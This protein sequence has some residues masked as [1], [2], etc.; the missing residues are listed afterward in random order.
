MASDDLNLTDAELDGLLAPMRAFA[1]QQPAPSPQRAQASPSQLVRLYGDHRFLLVTVVAIE[2]RAPQLQ[3]VWFAVPE[4]EVLEDWAVP[5]LAFRL[6]I[7]IEAEEYA[8]LHEAPKTSSRAYTVADICSDRHAFATD[9]V[10]HGDG[11]A[12]MRWLADLSVGD[13]VYMWPPRQH[14]VPQAGVRTAFV[15]DSSALPA[16]LSI[17]RTRAHGEGSVLLTS[18]DPAELAHDYPFLDGVTVIHTAHTPGALSTAFIE[19]PWERLQAVW[20]AGESG[21]MKTIR[22]F[23]RNTLGLNK[24]RAQVHGYWRAGKT[25]TRIDIEKMRLMRDATA[26]GTDPDTLEDQLEDL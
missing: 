15:V 16:A 23:C 2:E 22:T 3:R 6:E 8:S 4:D 18:A 26:A 25:R 12:M 17:L 24:H 7:P 19:T 20:A 14:T 11:S 9:I 5:N 10:V 13:T 1:A 21:E